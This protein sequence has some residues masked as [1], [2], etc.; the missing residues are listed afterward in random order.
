M[1]IAND[2]K[3]VFK[4][5]DRIIA[6][7]LAVLFLLYLLSGIYVIEANQMGVV[8]RLG[9]KRSVSPP[10]ISYH[11][12]WPVERVRKVNVKE[13]Q[14][15]EVGFWPRPDMAEELLPYCITGDKN[16]I[17]NR[18]VIQY[19]VADPA[20]FILRAAK[21]KD[22]LY[23]LAQATVLETVA[24]MRVDP[25]LTTAKSEMEAEI[26][27][28]LTEELEEL[29]VS[30]SIVGVERQFA[31]PPNFVKDAFQDV[32]NAREEKR[33]MIHEAENYRNQEIPRAKGEANRT[34]QQAEGYKVN[35]LASAR[36][37]S[38]RFLKIYEKYRNAPLV[39]R[40]RM[41][42]EMM[43][44]ALPNVKVMVL[45]TDDQGRPVKMKLLQA[46]V[47]TTPRLME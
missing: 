24:A 13:V 37:E 26:K 35:R 18:Y 16:I 33:T 11:L 38:D 25:V 29:G 9:A 6:A 28:R 21:V 17:H 45:A 23:E 7:V 19:R 14:R 42:I 20:N 32:T 44:Q 27:K 31:E 22:I 8:F 12:P 2:I 40:H 30:I 34:I 47:P 4:D 43:E 15:I 46:P 10:G 41:F 1:S 3:S 36:G 39:T 5:L